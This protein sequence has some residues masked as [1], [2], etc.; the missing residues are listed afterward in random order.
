MEYTQTMK[1]FPVVVAM[2]LAFAATLLG[3]GFMFHYTIQSSLSTRFQQPKVSPSPAVS[4]TPS[5]S[6]TPTPIPLPPIVPGE[7][8][9]HVP[10]LLYHYVGNNPNP[11]DKGRDVL[12]VPPDIFEEQLKTLRDNGYTT[13][14]LDDLSRGLDG[15]A[16]P[17]KPVI[18][19]FDDGYVDFYYNVWPLLRT[20]NMQATAFIPM[21]LLGGGAY[22]TWSMVEEVSRSS[23]VTIGAHSIT[24]VSL[25]S[26]SH[27]RLVA[28]LVDSKKLLEQH[29]GKPVVWMAYP[30]GLFDDRVVAE[31]KRAG[32]A[33]SVTTLPGSV[34]YKS[35]IYH[36]P[37]YRAGRRVGADFLRLLQ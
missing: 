12:S 19:T 10:I 18:L 37:R 32:Y 7:R 13:I 21:G 2:I 22:M 15:G 8:A 16:L 33:G 31:V 1:S 11:A 27:D 4:P 17:G 28:E 25:P 9:L 6:P 20:Y 3:V 5:L 34:Q 14:T 30:Y 26:L 23:V 24:H 29:T 36:M 35:R